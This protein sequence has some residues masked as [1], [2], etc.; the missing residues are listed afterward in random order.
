MI[1]SPSG[2]RIGWRFAAHTA[3]RA[4]RNLSILVAAIA[5]GATAIA[6]EPPAPGASLGVHAYP[7]DQQD[8]DQQRSDETHCFG[9]ARDKTGVDPFAPAAPPPP[10]P[11]VPPAAG[12]ARGAARGA[13]SNAATDEF[14]RAYASCLG[15]RGYRVM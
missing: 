4:E 2:P 13:A 1:P 5:T 8:A 9:G 12:A 10:A 15:G 14:K 11:A 3:R 6:Q 7:L